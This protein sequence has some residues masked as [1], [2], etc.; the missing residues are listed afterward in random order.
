MAT[1]LGLIAFAGL[2]VHAVGFEPQQSVVLGWWF[3][4]LLYVLL[5]I[6]RAVG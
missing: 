6:A 3:I 2:V 1:I 5:T 4:L